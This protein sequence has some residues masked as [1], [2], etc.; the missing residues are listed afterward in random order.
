MLKTLR[1]KVFNIT[2]FTA[3]HANKERAPSM[4]ALIF[5]RVPY[6]ESIKLLQKKHVLVGLSKSRY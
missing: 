5:N 2:R 1:S 3:K 4:G 6:P